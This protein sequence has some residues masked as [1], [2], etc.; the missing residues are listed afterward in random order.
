MIAYYLVDEV[1]ERYLDLIDPLDDEIDELEERDRDWPSEQVRSG[2]SEL[3]HDLL[4]IRRTLAPTRDAVRQIVD[5]RVDVGDDAVF[6]RALELH[7][8]DAYDSSC[9]PRSRSTS[10]AS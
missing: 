4:Q 7:F 6:D 3:R 10:R 1:A 8:A 5:G 9:A 2:S